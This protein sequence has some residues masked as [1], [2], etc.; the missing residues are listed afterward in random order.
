MGKLMIKPP[1]IRIL[2]KEFIVWITP[3]L[4]VTAIYFV[5]SGGILPLMQSKVKKSEQS[6]LSIWKID[7][8]RLKFLS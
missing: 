2:K 4:Y 6:S 7:R 3:L 1:L 5:P 8:Q